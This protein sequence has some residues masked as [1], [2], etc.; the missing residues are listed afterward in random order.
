MADKFAVVTGASSGIG[1]NLAKVFAENGYD[2]IVNAED[3]GIQTAAADLKALGVS[4]TPVQADLATF[5]GCKEFWQHVEASG[6]TLDAIA[7]NAGVGVG[8]LFA[9]TDLQ[10][11]IN[12]VRL[13]CESTVHIAK[14]AVQKMVKQGSGKIL[15]T[16]SIAGE[17]VAPKEAV[18]AASK[19]FDLSFSKSLRYELKDTGVTVT[20]LQP[21]P[22]DTNFF[23][24]A[25]LGDT[26]AG[27]EGKKES[28]P[29][30]VAKQ[31]FKA[32]M[33]GEDHVYSA[34]WKTKLEG[35]IMGVVPDSLVGKMHESMTEPANK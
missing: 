7:I 5:E 20:A 34:S 26:K 10:K 18:Y 19:A 31:G 24:R 14:Y 6:R 23:N 4:V 28:E 22:T 32:L 2:L 16:S 12:I 3:A 33:D 17:M 15:I 25:D 1:Y 29:Y 11:E 8:G 9:E 30:E 13:N 27:T 35:A 21:G